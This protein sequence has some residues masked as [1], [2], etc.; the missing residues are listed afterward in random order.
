MRGPTPPI[1]WTRAV[2]VLWRPICLATVLTVT[3]QVAL[4]RATS[5][6]PPTGGVRGHGGARTFFLVVPLMM[7]GV[8]TAIVLEQRPTWGIGRRVVVVSAVGGFVASATYFTAVGVHL[9]PAKPVLLAWA[10]LLTQLASLPSIAQADGAVATTSDA[11]QEVA[12]S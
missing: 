5:H 4:D 12:K 6:K 1:G 7:A 3:F 10:F 2:S 9:L 11:R 8:A